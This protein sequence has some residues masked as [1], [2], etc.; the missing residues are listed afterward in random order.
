MPVKS[1]LLIRQQLGERLLRS[2]T[3]SARIIAHRI[4]AIAFENMC[5]RSGEAD[6]RRAKRDGIFGL[7]RR[8]GIGANGELG[9]LGA[10][11]HQLEEVLNFSVPCAALSP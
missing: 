1:S 6:A 10:P 2:A 3:L 11:L 4:N 7:L 9:H 8:V 5:S